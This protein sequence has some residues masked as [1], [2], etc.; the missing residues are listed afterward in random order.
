MY[1]RVIQ[2]RRKKQTDEKEEGQMNN[3]ENN[4]E[5]GPRPT[6]KEKQEHS[7][8]GNEINSKTNEKNQPSNKTRF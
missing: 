4:K 8:Q 6:N 5:L 3:G 2:Q 1:N 7:N